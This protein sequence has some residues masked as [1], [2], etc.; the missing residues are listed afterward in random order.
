MVT[1]NIPQG[2]Y[3]LEITNPDGKKQVI[4]LVF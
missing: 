4:H 3:H 2:I 1:K